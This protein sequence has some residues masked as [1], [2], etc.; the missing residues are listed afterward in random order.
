[1]GK[2]TNRTTTIGNPSVPILIES[3]HLVQAYRQH[4][5]L[6]WNMAKQS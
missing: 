6:L 2:E 5:E 1:M 3:E 4:F